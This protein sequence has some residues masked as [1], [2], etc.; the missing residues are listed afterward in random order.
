MSISV[1]E[2]DIGRV[3]PQ[4]WFG[5]AGSV[6]IFSYLVGQVGSSCIVLCGS[7]WIIQNVTF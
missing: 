2:L 5:W 3:H 4:V 7:P 1:P 6:Q